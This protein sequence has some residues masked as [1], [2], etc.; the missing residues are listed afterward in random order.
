MGDY[1]VIGTIEIPEKYI[2]NMIWV[3]RKSTPAEVRT[4]PWG[5][6]EEQ[7]AVAQ[8]VREEKEAMHKAELAK[9]KGI[10]DEKRAKKEADATT[11]SEA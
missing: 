11:K 6:S 4:R 2:K 5:R 8:K 10:R 1:E 3:D 7:K 9:R